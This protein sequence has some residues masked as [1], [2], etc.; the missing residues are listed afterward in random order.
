M[1]HRYRTPA[2]RLVRALLLGASLAATAC[3]RGGGAGDEEATVREETHA[4][5]E[6]DVVVLDPAAV[7]AAGIRVGRADS[8]HTTGLPVTGTITYDANRVTHI[9]PRAAGRVV[10]LRADVGQRVGG[11]AALAILES[12]EIGQIRAE[13]R[14]ARA[15][16]RI[17]GEN[18]ARE[19]RLESQGISS[20]KELLE[21]EAELR[22]TE[23][24]LRSATERLRV[25][26]AGQGSGGQFALTT[27][28][29]GVVVSRDA[30][31]GA[32]AGP[33]D[34]L[35]TVA[36]LSRLWIELDIFER[37]LPRVAAGQPVAVTVASF[38]GRTFPGRI[39][40]VGDILDPAKR[41]VHAR[42][43]IPNPEAVLKPGMFA[44][45]KIQV[46]ESGPARAAVPQDAVQELEGRKVVFVPGGR[47]AEFRAVPVEVGEPAD[48]GRV[49]VL[50]GLGP[51]DPVVTAGAFSLRSELAK[52]EIGEHGH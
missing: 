8:V 27:P 51:G 11:G 33:T 45:G 18:H 48:A 17:A 40:Y 39:V 30:S 41:T 49:I 43:E 28:F 50:S 37:D 6:G 20:R 16:V 21:A 31:L 26:G 3:G 13:E 24:A 7:E 1:I 46:G 19:L 36:D 42:V 44:G 38:P 25:L 47:P 52:G 35:F 14:E 5:G 9:G 4:A 34:A 15:L 12:P 2:A 10:A 23:A 29:A 32:M 22:R